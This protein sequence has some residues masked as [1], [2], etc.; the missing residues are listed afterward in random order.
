MAWHSF[1]IVVLALPAGLA[2]Q[3]FDTAATLGKLLSRVD[4]LEQENQRLKS[5][6]DK[7]RKEIVDLQ[8]GTANP[9]LEEKVEV[10][11]QRVEELSQT[12]VEAAQK[13]PLKLSGLALMNSFLY[14]GRTGGEDLP[15][16]GRLAAPSQN[17]GGTFR[18]TQIAIAYSGAAGIFSA[19][20]AGKLQLDF[21]G[22][23]LNIQNHLARIRTAD[24]SL[25]WANRSLSFAVDKPILSPREPDS[26]SQLGISPLANSGNLWLWQPQLRYEERIHFTEHTGLR[27]RIG[28]YQTNETLTAVP[29]D[30]TLSRSRPA[31]QGRFELF[32]ET[33]GGRRFEIAPGFHRSESHIAGNRVESYA[34]SVDWL[35]P[36]APRLDW[37]GFAFTGENLTPLG[38]AGLRQGFTIRQNRPWGVRGKGGWSQV[39]LTLTDRIKFH[40]LGGMQDDVNRDLAAD[41]IARNLSY[42]A[43]VHFRLAPNVIFGVEAMQIRSAYRHSGLRL[44]NR[45][46]VALGYLF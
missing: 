20:I 17:A 19:Q 2:A 39:T 23:S 9:Q 7:L 45:Y 36:L 14:A 24:V 44:V 25:H 8:A 5:D 21:F 6:L 33:A 35:I 13:L 22:G 40:L 31:L 10:Q 18:N 28:V 41:G 29:A 42:G 16:V 27:A 3:S 38:I 1:A 30:L 46:D 12:K 26:L 4:Q 34:A 43:N 15:M 11:A 32:H 37:T